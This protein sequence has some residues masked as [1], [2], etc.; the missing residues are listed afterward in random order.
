MCANTIHPDRLKTLHEIPGLMTGS[1]TLLY[2]GA[3]LPD[4]LRGIPELKEAGYEV[5]I[6]E[7]WPKNVAALREAGWNVIEGSAQDAPEILAGRR[8]DVVF[9]WHG[10]EHVVKKELP[11]VIDGLKEITGRILVTGCPWGEYDQPPLCGNP[12]ERHVSHLNPE[13][14]IKAGMPETRTFGVKDTAYPSHITA[15]WTKT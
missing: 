15:W 4:G 9:W 6:L 2:I 8:F 5:T 3:R 1:G 12:H 13:D 14:M 11:K 7:V 10:P